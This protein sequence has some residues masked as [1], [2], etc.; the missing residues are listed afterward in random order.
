MRPSLLDCGDPLRVG[1]HCNAFLH[2]R[3]GCE[4]HD[5]DPPTTDRSCTGNVR[6]RYDTLNSITFE[7]RSAILLRDF[8]RPESTSEKSGRLLGTIPYPQ[9]ALDPDPLP[10]TRVCNGRNPAVGNSSP[11]RLRPCPY[12]TRNWNDTGRRSGGAIGKRA[13]GKRRPVVGPVATRAV[14]PPSSGA[15]SALFASSFSV[16]S[17]RRSV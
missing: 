2:P 9:E 4:T 10:P 17:H 14:R 12:P 15:S 13:S 7:R 5:R 16:Q 6:T 1:T 11:N 3:L 8:R